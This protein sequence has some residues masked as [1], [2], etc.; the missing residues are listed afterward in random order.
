MP[1]TV[2]TVSGGAYRADIDGL[3][4]LAV[5]LVLVFHFRL[6][7]G[8]GEAGFMGVD[9]FFVI[10]GY[11]ITRIVVG[12]L[13]RKQFSFRKFYTHRVRRLA[14]ALQ[15]TL[16]LTAAAGWVLLLPLDFAEMVRQLVASQWYVANVYF[17][18]NVSYFGLG[19]DRAVLLHMW[20]LAVEEQFYL[21]YPAALWAVH[22]WARP[23]LRTALV[24]ALLAS[25]GLNLW[26]VAAKPGAV[27]Y[28]L[29]TRSW[30][31]LAGACL[32]MMSTPSQP[33]HRL[34]E[35]LGFS[36]LVTILAALL[37]H[38][39][40]MAVPGW[41]TLLPVIGTVAL[42]RAGAPEA[43][44]LVSRLFSWTPWV[45]V[46]RI[47]Y[48]AYLMHWPI[49]VLAT[50]TLDQ[51]GYSMP[52]R[53]GMFGLSLL[54]AAAVFQGVEQ[55]LRQNHTRLSNGRMLLGYATLLLASLALQLWSQSSQGIPSRFPPV[56]VAWAN[57]ANERTPP[58]A[59]CEFKVGRLLNT[60]PECHIGVPGVTP[61][62]MIYGD[63]HAWAGQPEFDAW[64]RLR[65]E[66][67]V[68][69][70]CH[71]CPPLVDIHLPHDQGAC[72]GFNAAVMDFLARSPQIRSVALVSTWLQAAE[73]ILT[74]KP[75]ELPTMAGSLAV[76]ERQLGT[77]L[78]RLANLDKRV[79]MWDPVPGARG[80]VPQAMARAALKS[81][82]AEPNLRLALT[83]YRERYAFYDRAMA[84]HADKV[85]FRFSPADVLCTSG[86][87]NVVHGGQSLYFDNGHV[88]TGSAVLWARELFN[89][90]PP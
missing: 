43:P 3:R 40:G 54:L 15:V 69:G 58:L 56:V 32:A 46:G 16:L 44:T 81:K 4:A 29:P 9:V 17:W 72:A 74:G 25:F 86:S 78:D 11:L 85:W 45:Y 31:L 80:N 79:M 59:A 18:K 7:E 64:L 28:L 88:S 76:F 65:G 21:L 33:Q 89:R 38:R 50:L 39:P 5:L 36:G 23:W 47:S 2:P 13:N 10:S 53:W 51:A 20:S 19:A 70:F 90:V 62:W 48:P 67:A 87:C 24:M 73:G 68:F 37:I 82:S 60:G 30:E 8:M 22:C 66:A 6:F 49:H 27:F 61:T 1:P 57:Q 12:Q 42:I 55:P 71:S 63:S 84:R 14:P 75:D 52:M 77:T 35:V 83:E 41:L 34:N 26:L